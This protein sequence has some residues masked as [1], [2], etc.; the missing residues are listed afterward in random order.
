MYKSRYRR[1]NNGCLWW[2]L[3]GWWW[4]FIEI[5]IFIFLG[6]AKLFRGNKT[7]SKSRTRS[8]PVKDSHETAWFLDEIKTPTEPAAVLK[9]SFVEESP[10][11]EPEPKPELEPEH[12]QGY[13]EITRSSFR[14]LPRPSSLGWTE[15]DYKKAAETCNYCVVDVETTGLDCYADRIIEIA[16]VKV[17]SG[18]IVETYDTFVNPG[19]KIPARITALTGITDADI[20]EAPTYYDIAEKV[21]DLMNDTT[22]IGHNVTFDLNFIQQIFTVLPD[23]I[24]IRIDFIDTWDYSRRVV[25]DVPNYKLQ[26]MLD[27]FGIDPGHAHRAIDD[28]K[29]TQKLF[30]ALTE[31]RKTEKERV[32][33]ERREQKKAVDD[34]RHRTY[35]K[36]PLLDKSFCFTGVFTLDRESMQSLAV[37]VGALPRDQVSGRTDFLVMGDINGYPEWAIEKKKG[38]AEKL[39]AKGGKIQI[40]DESAFLSMVSKAKTAL[41]EQG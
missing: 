8:A 24:S 4:W 35:A 20:S 1:K 18:Q 27:F 19:M 6:I 34:L 37:S 9:S 41:T 21:A 7:K 12:P 29:A 13:V 11:P 40:I 38:T 14:E 33:R 26:T 16:I 39:Q 5:Y 28:A 3:V 2:L 23:D 32:L 36:S 30:T 17:Q 22:A 31:Y 10:E 25:K 15:A